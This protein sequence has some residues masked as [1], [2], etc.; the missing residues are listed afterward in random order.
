MSIIYLWEGQFLPTRKPSLYCAFISDQQTN[1]VNKKINSQKR[2]L[3]IFNF[4]SIYMKCLLPEEYICTEIS[5]KTQV[6]NFIYQV[7]WRVAFQ[8]RGVIHVLETRRKI[9]I[10]FFVFLG[11]VVDLEVDDEQ[12]GFPETT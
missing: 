10:F 2:L 5:P 9:W 12:S 7:M 11:K 6:Y 1:S 4:P 8:P 3:G